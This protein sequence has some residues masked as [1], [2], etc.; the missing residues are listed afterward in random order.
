M[1]SDADLILGARKDPDLFRLLYDRYSVRLHRFFWRRT[2]DREVALDLTAETFAQAWFARERFQDLAGGSAG[3][4]L[5]TIAR[6]LLIASVEKQTLETRA[7]D[8]LRVE[9]RPNSGEPHPNQSWLDGLDQDLREALGELP[10]QQ[11]R[12]VELRIVRELPY[13]AI[14]RRLGCSPTA[15]RIRVS[16]GLRRLRARMEMD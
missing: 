14:G 5:F 13:A 8:E 12:A 6:R 16:R 4:W 2:D 3:P 7:L 11:R 1:R 15:A 9:V 10:S